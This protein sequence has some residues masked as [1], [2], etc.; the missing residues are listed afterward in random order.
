MMGNKKILFVDDET[1]VLR[2]LERLFIDTDY[3]FVSATSGKDALIL[4]NEISVDMVISD[5]RMPEMDGYTFLRHV[6]EKHPEIVRVVLSGYTEKE[7]LLKAVTDG[8]ALTYLSKPWEND[9]LLADIERLFSSAERTK[10]GG[11]NNIINS[12]NSLPALP[13]TCREILE[14]LSS[15]API[16]AITGRFEIE[17]AMAAKILRI[18]NSA[19][20]GIRTGSL[21]KAIIYLGLDTIKNIV[22]STEAFALFNNDPKSA[23]EVELLWKHSSVCNRILHG[24]HQYFYQSKVPESFGAAGLLHDVGRLVVL[25]YSPKVFLEI[26]NKL[27]YSSEIEVN[28]LEMEIIGTDHTQLGGYLM[29]WWNLPADIVDTCFCHHGPFQ[30]NMNNVKI[31]QLIHLADVYSWNYLLPT[32]NFKP[33]MEIRKKIDIQEK[34]LRLLISKFLKN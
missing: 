29:Q 12:V 33:I 21:K 1:N 15:D 2:S 22:L 13:T 31:H 26:A 9:K 23:A 8:T 24:L 25:Q 30:S 34:D 3:E 18:V 4:L 16:D 20:Y 11:V 28:A 32:N 7:T 6:R 19:F 5:I 10:S 14:L 27:H 17:P